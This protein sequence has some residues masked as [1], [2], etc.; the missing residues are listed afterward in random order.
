MADVTI[1]DRLCVCFRDKNVAEWLQKFPEI[2]LAEARLDLMKPTINEVKALFLLPV[3]W[4]ATCHSCELEDYQRLEL[5]KTAIQSGAEFVDIS[6]DETEKFKK[7]I[8]E[9]AK[10]H[11]CNIIVSYH[12]FNETP[13]FDTLCKIVNN[14]FSTNTDFVK[15]ACLI[16]ST[17]DVE[18]IYQ[19][20][21]HFDHII[22]FGMGEKGVETRLKMIEL[23]AMFTYVA[24]DENAKT[25]LGQPTFFEAVHSLKI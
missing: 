12:N 7:S 3:R 17:Q 13:N 24:T 1:Y 8:Q 19:L 5:L 25:A 15:V 18:N 23:G 10:K 20:Y 21:S 14:C 11:R 6:H 9:I 4:I 2:R 16:N 22:A